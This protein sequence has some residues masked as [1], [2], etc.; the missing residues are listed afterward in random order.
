MAA[1]H[2]TTLR[3]FMSDWSKDFESIIQS[4]RQYLAADVVWE[5]WC[6]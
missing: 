6:A 5:Q 1:D 3:R 2:E 4:Y